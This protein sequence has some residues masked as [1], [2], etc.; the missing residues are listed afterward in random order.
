[1]LASCYVFF[2]AGFETIATTVTFT[3]YELSLHQEV[4]DKVREECF[5][6][7]GKYDNKLSYDSLSELEYMQQ[8]IDGNYLTDN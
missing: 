4:Q 5:M 3:L 8:V 7:L 6:V 2:V 1:M